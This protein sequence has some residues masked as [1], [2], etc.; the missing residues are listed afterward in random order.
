MS[1]ARSLVFTRAIPSWQDLPIRAF[2]GGTAGHVGC[3]I[4]ESV[5][6]SAF[7]Q[8]GVREHSFDEFMHGRH[9]VLEIPVEMDE[10]D[11]ADEWLADQIGKPYDWTAILGFLI[12]RGGWAAK[13]SWYCS[14]LCGMWLVKGG[15]TLAT[16]H[17]RLGVRLLMEI[18]YARAHALG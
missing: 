14:E 9:L 11:V 5:V 2:E 13:E 1:L 10:P 8:G 3:R 4:G 16:D 12:W 17:R 6:H 15:A 18:A 7:W